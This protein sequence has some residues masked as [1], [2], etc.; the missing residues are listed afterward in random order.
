MLRDCIARN[1][2]VIQSSFE[3]SLYALHD[4]HVTPFVVMN[5]FYKIRS[6]SRTKCLRLYDIDREAA[7]FDSAPLSVGKSDGEN[8]RFVL[9]VVARRNG[10]KI[11]HAFAG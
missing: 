8:D 2:K 5:P 4:F 1:T 3:H 9:R 10:G 6:Y 11:A 7:H